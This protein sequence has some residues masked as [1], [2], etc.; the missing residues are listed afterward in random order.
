M[1][2]EM[3]QE[4]NML[5]ALSAVAMTYA[6]GT[7]A[8]TNLSVMGRSLVRAAGRVTACEYRSAAVEALAGFATPATMTYHAATDLIIGVADAVLRL[9][10]GVFTGSGESPSGP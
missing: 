1:P 4:S 7:G 9:T 3:S 10:G 8:L 2:N 6:A 5:T